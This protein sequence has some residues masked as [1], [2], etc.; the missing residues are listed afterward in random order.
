MQEGLVTIILPIYNT[1]KYLDRCVNSVLCQS[2]KNLEIILI[3]DGSSDFCASKC[4]EWEHRDSRIKVIHKK[5]EGLGEARNTGIKNAAGEYICF[6]DSDDYIDPEII[7]KAIKS[8]KRNNADIVIWGVNEV[9]SSG[10]IRRFT[11]YTSKEVYECDEVHAVILP[12][13]IAPDPTMKK[14]NYIRMSAWACMFSM[15]LIFT[16]RWKF[17]SERQFI[18][19]DV[20]SLLHLYR[21]VHRVAVIPECLYFYCENDSSLSHTYRE[22]RLEKIN[23]CYDACMNVC[24][25]A[26]YNSEVKK[27]MGLWY[28]SCIVGA[29]KTLVS[30]KDGKE[31]ISSIKNITTDSRFHKV[32]GDLDFCKEPLTRK[33]IYTALKSKNAV[34]IYT[35]LKLR[36]ALQK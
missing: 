17:L 12:D 15:N 34:L 25:Q 3:D 13:L 20:I 18:S 33:I 36:V 23:F 21:N 14:K 5:N 35:V 30:C 24:E 7:E 10:K 27:R 6:F 9:S 11:P 16:C 32:I 26:G 19:E 22:D 1:E 28:Y 4:D 31:S 8:I 2:Y 29:L